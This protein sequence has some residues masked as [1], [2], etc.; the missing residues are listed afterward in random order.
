VVRHFDRGE[1]MAEDV[2]PAM[3]AAA[4][5]A[6]AILEHRQLG[7]QAQKILTEVSSAS[8]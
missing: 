6:N 8:A 7:E 2:E 4:K 5:S 1:L 3:L